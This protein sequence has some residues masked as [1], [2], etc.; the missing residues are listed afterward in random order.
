M[1]HSSPIP[2]AML[3]AISVLDSLVRAGLQ[4]VVVSPGSRNAPLTYALA[5][6]AEQGVVTTHVRIDERTAGFTALGMAKATNTPVAVVTTSG[7]AVGELLPA[8]MEAAHSAV[9]L[10][11]LSADRPPRLRGTGANQTT[12]QPGIFHNFVV[13]EADL[14]T[15]PEQEPGEQT[16]RFADVMA[17]AWGRTTEN[18]DKTSTGARGPVHLNLA[19]DTPLTPQPEAAGLLS[20]WASQLARREQNKTSSVASPVDPSARTWKH[21]PLDDAPAYR[22]VVIAGD[23]AGP[24]AHE[25]AQHQGLP[26]FAEPS[27]G[28]SSGEHAIPAY[29]ELHSTELWRSIE[30]IV[31]FGHPTLSRPIAALLDHTE[32][33]SVLY[34]PVEPAWYSPGRR[35]ETPLATLAEL[36]TFAGNGWQAYDSSGQSWFAAWNKAGKAR[37]AELLHDVAAYRR[38]GKIT[39]RAA[40]MSLALSVWEECCT[41]GELLMCGSSNLI[42]DLDVIAP[43]GAHVPQVMASRGLAGIDGTLAIA[44][45]AS[46]ATTSS[47]GAP[48]APVRVL[49]G[50]LTFLHD[51]SS[52]NIGELEIKPRVH[53]D[54][55]DDR[56]GGI[57]ATLEHGKLG[58]DPAFSHTVQRFFTTPPQLDLAQLAQGY[59]SDNGYT[60]IIHPA[61]EIA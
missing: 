24:I 46:L 39:G 10:M 54:V 59:G 12:Q 16:E 41:S 40:G 11:V 8:V 3:T 42:R 36:A 7:T 32:I 61:L 57:F 55:L 34:T 51:V 43:W 33:P 1:V 18:W 22:T 52:L 27:S 38:T 53:V 5:A 60:V 50:D 45:G 30:R 9:P 48:P 23:G 4:H 19:F 47:A 35:P 26:L 28:I 56:G 29:R 14:T 31:L 15:Y 2:A 25:F 13:A 6:L 20:R 21:A 44:G 58:Q 17:K 49:C 37:H